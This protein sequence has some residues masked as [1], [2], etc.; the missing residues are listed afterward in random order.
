MLLAGTV[1]AQVG[2]LF[3]YEF[4]NFA[5]SARISALGGTHI[6]VVDD[7]INIAAN[8]PA[9]LNP[10]MHEQLSFSHAF[11]PADIHYGY[12]AGGYHHDRLNTTFQLGVR[13]VS[14]GEF[15]L[16]N[17]FGQV[18]GSFRAAEYGLTLGAGHQLNERLRA[19]LNLRM[20]S[21]QFETYHSLGLTA[22]LGLVYQDTAKNLAFTVLA[23]NM[24]YQLSPYRD[25]NP[26]P[27]PFEM[28]AGFTKRLA[29]L[30]FQFSIIYR[31]LD[32]WNILYDDP[33]S[34]EDILFLGEAP[35]GRSR[36]SLW[37]DNLARHFVV[38]GELFIGAKDNFRLRFGYSHLLR[39][40]LELSEYRSLAGFTYGVGI[41]INRFRIDYGRTTFH[42]AGG[43]NQLSIGTNL[44]EFR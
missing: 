27:L 39:Q 10:L 20:I 43:V 5:P 17:I 7:D 42:L 24:G 21:S 6:A 15:D 12:V 14:Y 9:V 30:P 19:G 18:E 11:H 36:T 25:A 26:E 8:N 33:N 41:K 28:Q 13:Y 44:K 35:T 40:E 23:R 29:Y 4:L 3:T 38:N 16:T 2:G 1:L 37:F 31:F 32:R 34:Q 22:D